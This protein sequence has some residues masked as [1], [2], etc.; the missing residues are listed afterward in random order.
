MLLVGASLMIRTLLSI[1]GAPLGFH[2]ERILT[3]RIP[4]SERRYPDAARRNTFLLESLRRIAD[5]P[6]VAAVGINAGLPPIYVWNFPVTPAGGPPVDTQPV[7]FQQ[8][9]ETYPKVMGLTQI[10]GRF[11]TEQEV[12]AAT[13]SAIVNQAFVR[14]YFGGG[15]TVGR[16]VHVP[17]LR[18]P[19][20]SQTDDSFQIVGVVGDTVNRAATHEVWPEMYVPFTIFGRADRILVLANGRPESLQQAVKAQ[21]YALDPVQPLME[22]QTMEKLLAQYAY[23]EPRFN[24]LLF[25]VFA[26]LGLALALFGIYGVIS[27]AVA[28]QTREI[29]IRIALGATVGGVVAMVLRLGVKLLAIGIAVG[30]AASLASVKLLKGLV[31]V[32]TFDPY[33]FAAVAVLLFAAGL[34]ASFWP[35]RRAARVDPVTALRE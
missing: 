31:R 1:Q 29:G 32:S 15:D 3:M 25:T 10:Q 7:M 17:R 35:A 34:F 22:E 23:S 12:H 30:L 28:Q 19:P 9:N 5:V 2:P 27:H 33:S 20:F 6:G 26:V 16:V 11:F 24:L 14:R 13:H 18:T 8:T 21:I 4:F